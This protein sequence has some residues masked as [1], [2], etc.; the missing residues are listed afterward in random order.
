M[1]NGQVKHSDKL[2][3]ADLDGEREMAAFLIRH[4]AKAVEPTLEAYKAKPGHYICFAPRRGQKGTLK[5]PF[6]TPEQATEGHRE[7]MW[8]SKHG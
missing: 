6:V 8:E 2:V 3:D 4:G 1:R 5:G 7:W